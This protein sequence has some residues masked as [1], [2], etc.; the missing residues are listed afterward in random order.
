M[1]NIFAAEH[2]LHSAMDSIVDSNRL[3]PLV[4]LDGGL[5]TTLSLPPYNITFDKSTPLWSSHLLL[6]DSSLQTLL[7]VQ[8]CFVEAGAEVILTDTYQASFEGFTRTSAWKGS[9]YESEICMR[10]AVTVSRKAFAERKGTV[11]LSLGPYGATM[12][13]G[14]EYS[15][16][17][18]EEHGEI[19][20]LA[21][22]HLNRLRVFQPDGTGSDS[23]QGRKH[24]CWNDVDVVAFETIPMLKE[25]RVVRQVMGSI[26]QS[27]SKPFWIAC[28]FPGESCRMPDGTDIQE[29]VKTMLGTSD[30]EAV[31]SSIG[32]NCTKITKVDKLIALFEAAVTRLFEEGLIKR[33]PG[34][35]LYPDGTDGEV[36]NTATMKWEQK[37]SSNQVS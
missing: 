21:A 22:W 35:V 31:P 1:S 32:L 8:E 28:V 7:S 5:G 27:G 29:L 3:T 25:V 30:G 33:W 11:A 16:H 6:E 36:Y 2:H 18:D 24:E 9:N 19:E 17:Y 4:I 34:L 37:E 23:V 14:Q 12:I 26:G 13:P 10:N 15:G 20:A